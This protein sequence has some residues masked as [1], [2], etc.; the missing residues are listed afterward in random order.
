MFKT[1]GETMRSSGK[2]S[3]N[4]DKKIHPSVW[5]RQISL[6]KHSLNTTYAHFKYNLDHCIY[7]VVPKM[8]IKVAYYGLYFHSQMM[9]LYT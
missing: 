2:K 3:L 1:L 4:N 7:S 8:L 5:N 6:Q 9:I